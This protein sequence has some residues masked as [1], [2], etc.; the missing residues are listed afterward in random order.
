MKRSEQK[1]WSP[2][3]RL[4]GI[5]DAGQ[6]HTGIPWEPGVYRFRVVSDHASRGSELVYVGRGGREG[7]KGTSMIV[8]RV[9]TFMAAAMGFETSH[10]G[11]LR[12]YRTLQAKQHDLTVRDLEVSWVV[13]L[14]SICAEAE[15]LASLRVKPVFNAQKARTCRP[16]TCARASALWN[17]HELW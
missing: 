7:S 9:G 1:L 5:L 2:W 8:S 15:V 11:G 14:D 12:L 10:S 4:D 17:G 6:N 13:D 16:D 3:W